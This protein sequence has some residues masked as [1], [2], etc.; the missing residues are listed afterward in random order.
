M[1]REAFVGPDIPAL[2]ARA[3]AALGTNAVV[4]SVRRLPRGGFEMVAA[5]AAPV[6]ARL[7][8]NA[9]P[10]DAHAER[11]ALLVPGGFPWPGRAR[12]AREA[13]GSDREAL[14][15]PQP[16]SLVAQR[17]ERREPA[18]DAAVVPGVHEP[19]AARGGLPAGRLTTMLPCLA[20]YRI[21]RRRDPVV[22]A[23]VGPTG[24]GKTTTIAKLAR[25]PEVFDGLPVGLL[26]LDTYRIGAVEQLRIYADI[27]R[28]PL[29]VAYETRDLA[30]A[31]KRLR[32]REIV[33]VDTAGRGPAAA[34]DLAETR[35]RLEALMPAEVH[36][37]LP[38]GL[39]PS[40]ARALAARHRGLGVT[41]VIA[42]KLDEYPGDDSA[43]DLAAEL[44]LPM[45]WATD[46]QEVP[47]DLRSAAEIAGPAHPIAGRA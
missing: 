16:S 22:I 35:A 13:P 38:A 6:P 15:E 37:T 32:D 26:C 17:F 7:A 11:R 33:L 28:L 44:G 10:A 24:S 2:L 40:R 25:H 29:E 3:R 30:R 36:L 19:L 1:S 47:T 42:T 21:G 20:D 31:M 45:R 43:F 23:L 4:L 8:R 12:T 9:A 14:L 46:G 27:A 41:H 34:A 39:Q 5:D 18:Q